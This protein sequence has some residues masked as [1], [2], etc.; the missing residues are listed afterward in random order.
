M[1]SVPTLPTRHP[2]QRAAILRRV[3]TE[4][5]RQGWSLSSQHADAEAYCL[6]QNYVIVADVEEVDSGDLLDERDGLWRIRQM[7]LAGL[8]DV[9]V[10]W[11]LDRLSRNIQNQQVLLYEFGIIAQRRNGHSVRV[12]SLTEKIDDTEAGRAY[13]IIAAIVG[14]WERKNFRA[15]SIRNKLARVQA[16]KPLPGRVAPYGLR[17]A[18]DEHSYLLAQ[19][20]QSHHVRDIFAWGEAGETTRAMARRLTD[21]GILTPDG[22]TV[23]NPRTVEYILRNPVYCGELTAYR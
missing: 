15:R 21:A 11:K 6:R 19:A 23:W 22:Q 8:L 16:G 14:E 20:P 9:I 1:S 2:M 13:V 18:D 10:V 4:E 5:Q 17:W 3:S 12:E 7:A